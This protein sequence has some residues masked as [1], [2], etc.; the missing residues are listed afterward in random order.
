MLISTVYEQSD[1]LLRDAMSGN[2]DA[3][4]DGVRLRFRRS[5]DAGETFLPDIGAK[6]Q[7]LVFVWL[8]DAVRRRPRQLHG[9]E[10]TSTALGRLW[11]HALLR[12]SVTSLM[13]SF[14]YPVVYSQRKIYNFIVFVW[15]GCKMY[16]DF[17][18][19]GY[20]LFWWIWHMPIV[21]CLYYF[22]YYIILSILCRASVPIMS[23]YLIWNH[24]VERN[25]E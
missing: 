22:V 18:G 5:F 1:R 14:C 23:A 21:L 12:R 10:R 8:L 16:R 19:V 6:R 25:L 7:H 2:A 11:I 15:H 4:N 24:P 17:Y 13:T 3:G 9:R 20:A